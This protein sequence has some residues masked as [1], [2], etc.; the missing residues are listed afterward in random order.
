MTTLFSARRTDL[1]GAVLLLVV[2][3]LVPE[4]KARADTIYTL[5][6]YPDGAGGLN[7]TGSITTDG[8]IGTL[9]PGDI[10]SWSF[11]C[12]GGVF[13]TLSG[14]SMGG[15]IDGALVAT[16]GGALVAAPSGCDFY[17]Q[18]LPTDPYGGEEAITGPTLSYH[19]RPSAYY[20][21]TMEVI[22]N[23]TL[24]WVVD[25]SLPPSGPYWDVLTGAAIFDP[26]LS[27]PVVV[28]STT[29]EPSS[30]LLLTFAS[31]C[32]IGYTWRQGSRCRFSA[33]S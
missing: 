16:V 28:A 3:L 17:S 33:A 25:G 22:E 15:S 10:L 7:L 24:E 11:Q 27:D 6:N 1:R 19:S 9:A 30:L 32:L 21:G 12:A 31:I 2:V 20:A 13:P 14:S 23:Q 5:I 18:A 26:Y 8:T 4:S 29:P